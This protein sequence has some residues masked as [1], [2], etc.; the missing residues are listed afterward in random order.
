MN[1]NAQ[2]VV[3]MVLDMSFGD[4]IVLFFVSYFVSSWL[5]LLYQL[6]FPPRK[7]PF[8]SWTWIDRKKYEASSD[9]ERFQMMLNYAWTELLVVAFSIGLVVFVLWRES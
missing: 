4:V 7:P 8:G 1:I 9:S 3:G 6:I 5:L 2:D